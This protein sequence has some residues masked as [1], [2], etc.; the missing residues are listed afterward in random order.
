MTFIKLKISELSSHKSGSLT[1]EIFLI[2]IIVYHFEFHDNVEL[3]VIILA[4]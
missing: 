3:Y 1:G 2:F 4:K